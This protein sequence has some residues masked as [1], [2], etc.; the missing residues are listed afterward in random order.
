MKVTMILCDWAEAV[1]GKL[2][3]QGGGWTHVLTTGEEPLS[4]ALGLIIAVPWTEANRRHLLE[5]RLLDDDGAQVEIMGHPVMAGGQIEVGRP[6]GIKP[7]SDLNAVVAFKFLGLPLRP[8]GYVFELKVNDE[9][10]ART[11]F[12]VLAPQ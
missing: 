3:S 1:E 11:P 2:Y 9:E 7:G 4:M 5:V 10:N 12:W 6:P 8:S